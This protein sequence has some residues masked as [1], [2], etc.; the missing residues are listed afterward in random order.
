[1]KFDKNGKAILGVAKIYPQRE[2]DFKA[3]NAI[4]I[5]TQKIRKVKITRSSAGVK[6][7]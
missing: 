2:K 5:S 3:S 6:L 4:S 1:M 7:E